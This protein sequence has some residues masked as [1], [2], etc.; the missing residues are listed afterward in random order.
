MLFQRIGLVLLIALTVLAAI[1]SCI[2]WRKCPCSC[3]C[4]S[5]SPKNDDRVDEIVLEQAEFLIPKTLRESAKNKITEKLDHYTD[6]KRG[7]EQW[8]KCF[9]IAEELLKRSP[10]DTQSTSQS[11]T[12]SSAT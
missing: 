4:N 7:I 1:T 12:S 8:R 11:T 2:P 9:D 10:E 5:V 6:K 3:P